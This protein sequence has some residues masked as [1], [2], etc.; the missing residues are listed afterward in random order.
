MIARYGFALF[1]GLFSAMLSAS[2]VLPMADAFD[3]SAHW[4]DDAIVVEANI[5][6][7]HYLYQEKFSF[8]AR[9]ASL[10][11]IVWPPTVVLDDPF[12]GP[13]AVYDGPV[14]WQIPASAERTTIELVVHF[15]GCS[16]SGFCYPPSSTIL[17]L[18]TWDDT[19]VNSPFFSSG[20]DSFLW[21]ALTMLG[22][23][24]L[25]SFTPC[26]LPMIPILSGIIV[27]QNNPSAARG[28]F[29][30]TLYVL[31]MACAYAAGGI[32]AAL[33]GAS[34]NQYLQT[35]A[36]VGAF[37][38]LLLLF[39]VVL[40]DWVPLS[41]RPSERIMA[42]QSRLRGLSWVGV[43]LMGVLATLIASPCISL[44]LLG[45]LTYVMH[46][47]DWWL[48]GSSLFLLGLGTGIPLIAF[49][50]V[51]GTLLPRLG[52]WMAHINTLFG[53]ILL[54]LA[55][56]LVQ[57][58]VDTVL[59]AILW[60]SFLFLVGRRFFDTFRA[61]SYPFWIAMLVAF[62][63]ALTPEWFPDSWRPQASAQLEGPW[64][65]VVDVPTLE[66]HR[67][68]AIEQ[69]QPLL[70][71]Y[72]AEWCRTCHHLERTVFTDDQITQAMA[73]WR[74]VS[75][76]VTDSQ[77]LATQ[78]LMSEYAVVA[79]PVALLIWP[80]GPLPPP[81][82]VGEFSTEDLLTALSNIP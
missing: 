74:W 9:G 71:F 15:Q 23:G 76:D 10:G 35:P 4:E 75:A 11:D 48:G 17:S 28:F 27:G 12:F 82:L 49:G 13:Q 61:L 31:G 1:L 39:T 67:Q 8:E 16:A 34:V 64:H 57:P 65:Q 44:P 24:L 63:W 51:G 79:P 54:A 46:T 33:L 40:W 70:L 62:A 30:S 7:G 81:Q 60:A 22:L 73:D 53:T 21:H 80:E 72:R 3:F 32:A 78:A 18:K 6:S 66:Q 69:Q 2:A 5:A 77:T 45:V 42:W 41:F 55:M 56:I 29:L 68:A 20:A 52:G 38:L 14:S 37:G 50:T 58:F 19:I 36:V 59:W 47:Q 26:V 25:L 43:F